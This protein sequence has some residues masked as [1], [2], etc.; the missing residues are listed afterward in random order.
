MDLTGGF[1]TGTIT[2]SISTTEPDA[3]IFYTMDGTE[4]TQSSSVYSSPLNVS[5]IKIIK[6]RVFSNNPAILPGLME[7]NTYILNI[8][9]TLPVISI[10]GNGLEELLNGNAG[11]IPYGSIEYFNRDKQR[12]TT[13]YGDFNKHGQDSWVHPQRSIDYVTRDECGYNYA[14]KEKFFPLSDRDE[15]Q[16]IILRACGDDNYP[17]IDSSA[18]IR[19][20]LVETLSQ[21]AGQQLDWRKSEHC[22]LYVNGIYWGIYSIREKVPDCDYTQYYYGQGK[23]DIQF[24]MLWGGTWAEYGGEQALLDWHTFYDYIMDHDVTD[25][26]VYQTIT[27]QLDVTSLVDYFIINSYVVCSDWLNWNV[28][29]WRGLNPEGNHLRWAYTLWDE[30]A[31]FGH[32][33]NYTGIPAQSPYVS[34][35]YPEGLTNQWQDP[36]GHVTLLNKLRENPVF[37]QY[38]ISRYIDLLNTAFTDDYMINLVDSMALVIEPEMEMQCYRWGGNV[39]QWRTNVQKIRNFITTRN[40]VIR[41]GLKNCYALTGPYDLVIDADPPG[42]GRIMINSLELNHFPWNGQYF[43]GVDIKLTA[44]VTNPNYEFDRWVLLNH[45]VLPSDTLTDVV[46]NIFAGDSVLALFKPRTFTDSL[47]INEINYNSADNFDPGDWVEFYNPLGHDLDITNW[48]FR[49]EDDEHIF[50]FP[51]GTSIT[52]DG[53]LV[54]CRDTA[55]FHSLFPDVVT[56]MGNMDFGLS[57]NGE[58]IRL[59][60]STGILID[61]VLYDDQPPWPV[62]PDGNGSTLQLIDPSYDNALAASWGASAVHGTP[63]A[64]NGSYVG[65]PLPVTVPS[66]TS[67]LHPNPFKTLAY[68]NIETDRKIEGGILAIYNAYGHQVKLID[69]IHQRQIVIKRDGLS[70]GLYIYRFYD[71]KSGLVTTGKFIIN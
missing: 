11:L 32:Y 60:D 33:V 65:M 66:M 23:Y 3:Q 36:E 24:I 25:P 20:D 28:A 55:A 31:T 59:L 37:S 53:Y 54:L 29:W 52:S 17:G 64:E 63:G 45:Q 70:S 5:S 40:S 49:D 50:F 2:V 15:F 35:C 46:L 14:L 58:L 19:D 34:P 71:R 10:A 6:A 48:Q 67:E 13:A 44:E 12:T 7:Y 43:G 47:V 16:R 21:M 30:D 57:A 22:I 68:L 69:H 4:P 27:D 9:F 38:Y 8:N 62:E 51:Q 61:T 18:H 1:Y 26:A 56:Y 39:T 42:V 41:D